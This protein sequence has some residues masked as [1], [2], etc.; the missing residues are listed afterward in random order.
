MK[1]GLLQG[2]EN[3]I[4]LLLHRFHCHSSKKPLLSP[5]SFNTQVIGTCAIH[6]DAI[7]DLRTYVILESFFDGD[8][9][10]G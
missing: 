4:L 10:S 6:I 8:D 7:E 2:K 1:W 5:A 9:S 3:S